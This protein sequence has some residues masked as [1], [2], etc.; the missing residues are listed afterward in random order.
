MNPELTGLNYEFN[1]GEITGAVVRLTSYVNKESFDSN[2]LI[3]QEDLDFTQI[4][5]PK[6]FEQLAKEKV[7]GWLQGTGE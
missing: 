3:T 2:I 6:T 4:H 1:N 5:P 7:I